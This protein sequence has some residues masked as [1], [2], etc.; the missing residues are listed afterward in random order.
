MPSPTSARGTRT[1]QKLPTIVSKRKDT[2]YISGGSLH[3]ISLKNP[4]AP[5]V[6]RED[7]EEP[8]E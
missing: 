5:A 2:P 1:V 3:W 8:F 4:Q 6:R 7:E